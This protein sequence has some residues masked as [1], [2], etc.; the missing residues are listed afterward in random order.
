M[1]RGITPIIAV[2][3]LIVM[4]VGIAAFVFI[5]MQNFVSNLQQTTQQQIEAIQRPQF[6]IPYAYVNKDENNNT[7]N[8]SYILVNTGTVPINAT[9]M[10][11]IIEIYS[12]VNGT[13]MDVLMMNNMT[14]GS[15]D[16]TI[17]QRNQQ[18][19]CTIDIGSSNYSI[20]EYYYVLTLSY[21]GVTASYRIE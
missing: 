7:T 20:T 13:R 15:G 19:N 9:A 12:K 17:L 4:T 11:A 18:I 5:W 14:C 2:I 10:T 3:L 1:K 21:Q 8:I 6:Y 16:N